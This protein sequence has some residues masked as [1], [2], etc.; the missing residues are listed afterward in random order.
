MARRHPKPGREATTGSFDTGE[1]E[2]GLAFHGEKKALSV[3]LRASERVTSDW[4]YI[5]TRRRPDSRR[6]IIIRPAIMMA[7]WRMK[8]RYNAVVG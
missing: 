8:T 1:I 6:I 3:S 2:D 4:G 7:L 5:A